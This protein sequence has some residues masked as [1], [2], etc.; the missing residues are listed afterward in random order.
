[1]LVKLRVLD[2]EINLQQ[3]HNFLNARVHVSYIDKNKINLLTVNNL[4]HTIINNSQ[5]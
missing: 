3:V 4:K 5:T 1:M 2:R